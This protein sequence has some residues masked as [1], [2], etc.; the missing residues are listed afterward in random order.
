MI[1][2]PPLDE[3]LPLCRVTSHHLQELPNAAL[4]SE[5]RSNPIG[6]FLNSSRPL[7]RAGHPAVSRRIASGLDD[8]LWA[9]LDFPSPL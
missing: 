3:S 2:V 9:A 5:T 4:W 1:R 6:P 8:G 7:G